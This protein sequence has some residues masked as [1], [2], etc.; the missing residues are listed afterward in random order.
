[1]ISELNGIEVNGT[2]EKV[3]DLRPVANGIYTVLI[4]SSSARIVKKVLVNK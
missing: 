1:M 2:V 3:I 4:R